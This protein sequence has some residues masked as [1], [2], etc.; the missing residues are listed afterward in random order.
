M[1]LGSRQPRP[2]AA[3][4]ERCSFGPVVRYW[5]RGHA[6]VPLS[7]TAPLTPTRG[8]AGRSFRPPALSL[9]RAWPPGRPWTRGTPSAASLWGALAPTAAE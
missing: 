4:E 7:L 5:R 3:D 1:W 2:G 8:P 6:T 9:C